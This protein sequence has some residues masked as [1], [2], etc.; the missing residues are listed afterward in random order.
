MKPDTYLL[1][2][3]LLLQANFTPTDTCLSTR[4]ESRKRQTS[5]YNQ[6]GLYQTL[7]HV[8]GN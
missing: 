2:S 3:P 6:R 5:M 4:L 1:P 8:G 7:I